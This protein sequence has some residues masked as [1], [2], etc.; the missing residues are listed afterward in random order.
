M[1]SET[2]LSC[3]QY[4]DFTLLLI[5]NVELVFRFTAQ[6]SLMIYPGIWNTLVLTVIEPQFKSFC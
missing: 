2:F 6:I 4:Y 1:N 5:N 3:T